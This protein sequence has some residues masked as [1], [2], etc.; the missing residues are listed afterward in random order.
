MTKSLTKAMM[1]VAASTAVAGISPAFAHESA[2][3]HSHSS[4]SYVEYEGNDEAKSRYE[5]RTNN[6]ELTTDTD[7]NAVS[8]Y[9]T[10][11]RELRG[12]RYSFVPYIYS[13]TYYGGGILHSEAFP[14]GVVRGNYDY[15]YF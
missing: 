9:T 7:G 15:I 6:K 3:Q 11:Q 5:Y 1:L 2:E 10:G 8:I 13:Q 12:R 4:V 14:A